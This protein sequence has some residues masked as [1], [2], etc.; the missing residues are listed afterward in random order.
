MRNGTA[1]YG[2]IGIGNDSLLNHNGTYNIALGTYTLQGNGAGTANGSYN[3]AIGAQSFNSTS[4]T[5]AFNNTSIGSFTAQNCTTCNANV[6]AGY[7]AGELL[8]TDNVDTIVGYQAGANATGG[9][10]LTCVGAQAC[11]NVVGSNSSTMVGYA[12]GK[13]VTGGANTIIGSGVGNGTLTTGTFNILLGTRDT[14][15]SGADTPQSGTQFFLDIGN[16][17]IADMHTPTIASGF[18]TSPSV[19]NGTS[20]AAFTVTVGTG[21][22]ASTGVINFTGADA[23]PHGWACNA[24]DTTTTSST[25]FV[26][27]SVP[28][29]TT[30]I[31]LTNYNTSGAA[32]AWAAGDVIAVTCNGY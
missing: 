32:A 4:M 28:T 21:G 3:V 15:A 25:V 27:K 11:Y 29:S 7:M 5:T 12:A 24:T 20:N 19:S 26:T 22:T 14:G 30:S 17:I 1:I 8:S 16:A 18:G 2:S 9:F 31:T 10:G 23:A 6:L 13:T